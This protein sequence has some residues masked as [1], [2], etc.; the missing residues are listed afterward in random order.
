MPN[1]PNYKVEI[2]DPEKKD[3]LIG[4]KYQENISYGRKANLS[5]TCI[6]LLT[7][8]E[9]FKEMWEDN[10][11]SMNEDVRP[12]GRIFALKTGDEETRVLYEPIS[13]TCFLLDCDY[14]GYVKSLALAVSGDFLEEYHSIHSRHSV[15]RAAVDYRGIGTAIIA[16]SGVG[17]TTQAYGLL[18]EKHVR[19]I[20][21]DWFYT[22][23]VGNG[24]D[25]Q[26]SEKNCY[27]RADIASD[28][29]EYGEL[30]EGVSLDGF[31]RTVT[32][33]RRVL[34]KTTM[35]EN[36]TLRNVIHLKRDPDDE[37][38]LRKMKTDEAMEYILNND[39]CNPHRLVTD[40]RKRKLRKEFFKKLYER[41][42]IY[43][44]NTTAS[45]EENLEQI[46]DI[47]LER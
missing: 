1:V 19:L 45:I 33:V 2:M 18:L 28:I 47:A 25:V 31:G 27:I 26:A 46:K 17:K 5:G 39:F 10:F 4:E 36:T 37:K 7:N 24:V 23:I 20:A 13:K 16:P 42:D 14:Y 6:K 21:D 29:K 40:K 30:L 11:K 8:V 35:K 44:V 12:H 3:K 22:T 34:G 32:N 43:M 41:T 38:I 9:K 15:H